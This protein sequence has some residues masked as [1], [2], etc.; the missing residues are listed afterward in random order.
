[1]TS[2]AMQ[3]SGEAYANGPERVYDALA[4]ALVAYSPRPLRGAQVLDVGAGTGSASRAVAAAGG[5]VV[6]LD[7]EPAMLA[8]GRGARPPAVVGEALA[9]PFRPASFDAVVAAFLL[10]H[11]D[12]AGAV[13]DEVARVLRPGGAVLCGQF[14]DWRDPMKPAIDEVVESYGFT[15]PAW[16]RKLKEELEPRVATTD[17]VTAL[18]VGAGLT[19]AD[20]RIE[21]VDAGFF[22]ARELVA[23]RLGL[24]HIAPFIAGLDAVTRARVEADAMRAVGP[25]RRVRC[26][27]VFGVAL[28]PVEVLRRP[29]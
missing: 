21:E 16:Y 23:Y 27:V 18:A 9:L 19:G 28:K 3:Y 1:V 5:E 24:A 12:D 10:N 11:V 20:G 25:G 29:G 14:A 15:A 6:A 7:L 8:Y 17:Q 2:A 4:R 26:R 13:L 22:T